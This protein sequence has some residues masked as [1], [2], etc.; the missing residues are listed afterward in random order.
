MFN[1]L[2][3][4]RGYSD[5]DV[6]LYRLYTL[7]GL[8]LQSEGGPGKVRL[9]DALLPG[10]LSQMLDDGL[11]RYSDDGWHIPWSSLYTALINDR[12]FFP[13]GSASD[14]GGLH[15]YTGL[16]AALGLPN[17]VNA[18]MVLLN[19]GTLTDPDFSIIIAGWRLPG[20]RMAHVQMTGAVFDL[21]GRPVMMN[22]AQWQLFHA[23]RE[24]S[25]RASEAY[26]ERDN[27]LWWGRIRMLAIAADAD[28]ADFLA[29]TVVLTPDKISLSFRR[30]EISSDDPIIE[31]IPSFEGV[32][33]TWLDAFDQTRGVRERYDIP[34]SDGIVQV[35]VGPSVRTVLTEIRRMPA[36]RVAGSRAQALLQNPF[37]T[38]GEAATDAIDEE[39]FEKAREEAGLNY[40]RFVPLITSERGERPGRIG[41]LV[42]SAS[43]RGVTSSEEIWLSDG[44]LES[45]LQVA[46]R[47]LRLKYQLI[48]WRG[49][50]LEVQGD[51]A[52]YVEELRTAMLNRKEQT[53]L[54]TY[55]QVHDLSGYSERIEGV[56]IEKPVYSPY[57]A[58]KDEGAGWFP[59]TV[60]PVLLYRPDDA[61]ESALIPTDRSSI[62]KLKTLTASARA[63]G[64]SEVLMPGLPIP[65]ALIEAEQIV[66]T[67]EAVFSEIEGGTGDKP[68]GVDKYNE[69]GGEGEQADDVQQTLQDSPKAGP[70]SPRVS[71]ILRQNIDSL[72]YLEARREA[73]TALPSQPFIPRSIR[74]GMM[75]KPHQ[76]HGLGWLQHLYGL[77]TDY[78]VRGAILADDM[79]LGKTFQLLALMASLIEQDPAVDPMLVV[80]PVSLLENWADEAAKFFESGTLPILMAYGDGL[81][82]LRVPREQID[83]RLRTE[84]GLVRFLKPGWVGDARIVLTTYETLRDLEFSFAAQKWS[85]MVCDEAQRIKNPAAMVTRSAKK[86]QA[87][88]RIAC[89]GTPVENTLQD[90]WCLFDYIQPGLLGTLREFGQRYRKPIE[91]R[92]DQDRERVEE[93]RERIRPQIL[94]RMKKDVADDL[95]RKIVV[96][97]CRHLPISGVQRALYDAVLKAYR[98]QRDEA[99]RA[100]ESARQDT[101]EAASRS[102]PKFTQKSASRDVLSSTG[103]KVCAMMDGDRISAGGGALQ[104]IGCLRRICTDPRTTAGKE[105]T[106]MEPL[107][108]YRRR[109]PKMDWL[110]GTLQEIRNRREKVILFCEFRDI[111]RL[112]QHYI[113]V[114][115]AYDADIINGDVSASAGAAESRQKRISAFQKADGFGVLILSPVAVGFGVNIQAANHVIHYTRTWNPAKEDQA[116]DRAYRIGQTRDVHVYYPTVAADDFET[117]DVKLDRLLNEKRSLANDM[118]NGTGSIS[119]EEFGLE[120]QVMQAG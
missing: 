20:G 22:A 25:C 65:L 36:R 76:L 54:V 70:P 19:H 118:L 43:M 110:I 50:E 105:P 80:A 52:G 71:L 107:A 66:R 18:R 97:S 81:R 4:I 15:V 73:L 40:E 10:F 55:D 69:G 62:G 1:I 3:R 85:V 9:S 83:M 98:A 14:D 34:T 59:D 108:E 33:E 57:I 5:S 61:S 101:P 111:Q 113:K 41:L 28:M 102:L 42:E 86:Q 116:T 89:T 67:F 74:Q 115:L 63:A 112:L 46:T 78:Q 45:F 2:R 120:T 93:L 48:C 95:P 96:D 44:E 104:A 31:V 47:A 75:L 88:F 117:F 114:A 39:Q 60:L 68:A 35:I 6:K 30:S 64:E 58:K 100:W 51:T 99:M 77:R 23:V 119:A 13:A 92:N 90:I 49:Y 37:A 26:G 53:P 17:P 106:V 11:G 103:T 82:G 16:H 72:Q 84:D 91:A 27:R 12:S 56:G 7:S 29:R 32:P 79:G 21:E 38:L 94:R 24:F 109:A 87:T 8:V